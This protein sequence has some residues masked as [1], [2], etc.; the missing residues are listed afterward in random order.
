M[1]DNDKRILELRKKVELKEKELGAEI[2]PKY[3]TNLKYNDK[4]ILIMKLPE[5]VKSMAEVSVLIEKTEQICKELNIPY[6]EELSDI[7]SDLKS[8]G[9][10]LVYKDKKSE[11]NKL[12]SKLDSLRSERLR[13]TDELDNLEGIL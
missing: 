1:S 9:L 11:L 7:Y 6:N 13:T 5:I 12:K 4:N 8:K 10:S 3:L 2:K